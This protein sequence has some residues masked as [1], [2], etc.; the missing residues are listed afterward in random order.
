MPL[1]IFAIS[2][3]LG[4]LPIAGMAQ[5]A[6]QCAAT[7]AAL[8]SV[9]A[10]WTKPA[11]LTAATDA[12]GLSG[13]VLTVGRAADV[14]L[15]PTQQVSYVTEPDKP[16][17]SVSHGGMVA[18]NIR[19]AGTYRVGLNSGAW[20]DLVK[21]NTKITSVAH[22]HGPACS[23]IH[24]VVDFPLTPGRYVIQIS[25]NAASRNAVMVVRRP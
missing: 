11:P 13:A 8:P 18:L 9:F 15:H 2:V 22:G 7:N 10:S 1:K 16:G 12:G 20:I 19:R 17:G 21:G 14:A 5:A 24:K 23:T 25:A 3:V 4:L 6:P